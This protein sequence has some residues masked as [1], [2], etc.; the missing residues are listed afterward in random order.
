M[1]ITRH[2][3][4]ERGRN[5]A[6]GS[7]M[8]GIDPGRRLSISMKWSI[9][10]SGWCRAWAWAWAGGAGFVGVAQWLNGG[11]TQRYG[12]NTEDMAGHSKIRLWDTKDMAGNNGTHYFIDVVSRLSSCLRASSHRDHPS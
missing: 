7:K 9:V 2:Q 5:V 11:E 12:G 8:G 10:W 4:S 1:W 3:E 6:V